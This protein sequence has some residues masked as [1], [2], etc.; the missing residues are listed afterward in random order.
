MKYIGEK[1]SVTQRALARMSKYW[2]TCSIQKKDNFGG[3]NV[4]N[5]VCLPNMVGG[6]LRWGDKEDIVLGVSSK[7]D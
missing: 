2:R 6:A 3:S 7:R 5:A 1:A 4:D